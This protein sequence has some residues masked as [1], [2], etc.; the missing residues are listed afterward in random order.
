LGGFE[1]MVFFNTRVK[2]F[3]LDS[4]TSESGRTVSLRPSYD[5]RERWRG[6]GLKRNV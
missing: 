4:G 3:G 5:T 2:F 6:V 1:R